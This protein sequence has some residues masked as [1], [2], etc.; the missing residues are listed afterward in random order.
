M[1]L[2]AC[3]LGE[4]EN[5]LLHHQWQLPLGGCNPWE[6]PASP[7]LRCSLYLFGFGVVFSLPDWGLLFPIKALHQHAETCACCQ[8]APSPVPHATG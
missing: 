8:S 3:F 5:M 1:V 2:Y 4:K 6:W 7:S